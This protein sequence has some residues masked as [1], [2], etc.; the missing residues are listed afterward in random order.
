MQCSE[1]L[2]GRCVHKDDSLLSNDDVTTSNY[3]LTVTL[4]L[5]LTLTLTHSYSHSHLQ[6]I[7]S[8]CT[9]SLQS[10]RTYTRK[11]HGRQ[12]RKRSSH[13]TNIRTIQCEPFC[14]QPGAYLHPFN[15][16]IGVNDSL[17]LIVVHY[18]LL[19]YLIFQDFIVQQ[20][21]LCTILFDNSPPT[22]PISLSFQPPAIILMCL[23]LYTLSY[24]PSIYFLPPFPF[25]LPFLLLPSLHS[26][27]PPP[28]PFSTPGQCSLCLTIIH[29]LESY[30]MV[31]FP[32]RRFSRIPTVLESSV[33]GLA[34][35]CCQSSHIQVWL[36]VCI[37][38]VCLCVWM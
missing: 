15:C 26:L 22:L 35:E 4:T 34:K 29:G 21:I 7:A 30:R 19:L 1:T 36:C 23:P 20:F 31:I 27:S 25:S 9:Y 2:F 13:A 6:L 37:L 5:T 12:H 17:S 8:Y 16:S 11:L 14:G 28:N 3:T 33:Q 10:F 32:L 24:P 38:C 18:C